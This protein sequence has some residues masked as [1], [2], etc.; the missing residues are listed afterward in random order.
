MLQVAFLLKEKENINKKKKKG[1]HLSNCLRV[2]I[3]IEALLSVNL[4]LLPVLLN[5]YKTLWQ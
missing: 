3:F 4:Y 5:S 2:F 1:H